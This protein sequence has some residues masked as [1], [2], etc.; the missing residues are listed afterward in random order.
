MKRVRIRWSVDIAQ[1]ACVLSAGF[2]HN[3]EVRIGLLPAGAFAPFPRESGLLASVAGDCQAWPHTGERPV[4]SRPLPDVPALLLA[5]DA[6]LRAPLS[7]ARA[8]AA[9]LPHARLMAFGNVGHDVLHDEPT[10]CAARAVGAFLAGAAPPRCGRAPLRLSPLPPRSARGMSS[11][12]LALLTVADALRQAAMRRDQLRGL[13]DPV[14]F[15]GLRGGRVRAAGDRVALAGAQYVA[16]VRV[17]GTV[18]GHGA[19]RVRL[20]RPGAGTVTVRLP[21]EW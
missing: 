16:G 10:G 19:G 17:S 11:V 13:V 3:S 21:G 8:V 15:G 5:G 20:T 14:A 2:L 12:R 1:V 9:Q 4:E 18:D 7:G 6:D